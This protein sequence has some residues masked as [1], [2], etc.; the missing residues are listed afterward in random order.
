MD[1]SIQAPPDR[2]R[3]WMLQLAPEFAMVLERLRL[4]NGKDTVEDVLYEAI[5]DFADAQGFCPPREKATKADR[6]KLAAKGLLTHGNI[7]SLHSRHVDAKRMARGY[8]ELILFYY[9]GDCWPE[10]LTEKLQCDLSQ[11]VSYAVEFYAHRHD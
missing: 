9:A 11:V 10:R 1:E 8:T 2:G 4:K 7:V 5:W 3:V 6:E